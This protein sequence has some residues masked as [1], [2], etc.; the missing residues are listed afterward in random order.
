MTKRLIP[1]VLV[2]LVGVAWLLN[3]EKL[4]SGVDWV[5]TIGLAAAGISTLLFGGCNRLTMVIGPFLLIASVTSILRQTGVLST[6]IE[7]PVLTIVLGVLWLITSLLK[8][9]VPRPLK[10]E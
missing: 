8:L 7:I 2:I 9:P 3:A 6:D 5:W 4:I 10:K 1:P